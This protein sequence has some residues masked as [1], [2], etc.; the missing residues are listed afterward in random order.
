[1]AI[2]IVDD[3]KL[4]REVIK[5]MLKETGYGEVIAVG[6]AEEALQTLNRQLPGK[7]DLIL[8]DVIMPKMSGIEACAEIKKNPKL[9]DI[10]VIMISAS[11]DVESLRH[12]F[13]AGAMD[14]ISKPINS[15]ELEVRVQSAI[16][17]KKEIEK[18]K[19][20]EEELLDVMQKLEKANQLLQQL[21]FID[22]L[23]GVA[24]RRHFEEMLVLKWQEAIRE[25]KPLSLIMID[26]DFFK[27]Y[28]DTYGHLKGDD[29]LKKVANQVNKALRNSDL[30]A[31][32]G[33]EEFSI[34]LPNAVLTQGL[35]IAEN[36]RKMVLNLGIPHEASDINQFVTVS[37]GVSSIYPTN[38]LHPEKLVLTA[39]KALYLSKDK[40]RNQVSYCDLRTACGA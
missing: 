7:I 8:L 30:L 22:G 19:A 26:I 13:V 3:S 36:A 28:N 18:R 32:Y 1:M 14:F 23:T 24:N 4:S 10:P 2:L 12:A 33:G 25:Q 39:D 15:V 35:I 5:R 34:L 11:N 27:K 31:R 21:S 29:C 20:R 40:G 17:L 9:K 37:V 16:K 38:E 6:S